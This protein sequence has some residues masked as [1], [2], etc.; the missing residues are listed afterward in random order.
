VRPWTA[1][2]LDRTLK[3]DI[4]PHDFYYE[5]YSDADYKL[6]A[7]PYTCPHFSTI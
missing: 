2:L 7:G 4:P 6:K 5:Y 1:A 3:E